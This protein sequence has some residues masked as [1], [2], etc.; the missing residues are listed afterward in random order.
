MSSLRRV[1][2]LISAAAA[3]AL[4]LGGCASSGTVASKSTGGVLGGPTGAPS[5]PGT[6]SSSP[7]APSSSDSSSPSTD[8]SSS[9]DSSDSGDSAMQQQLKQLAGVMTDPGCKEAVNALGDIIALQ[10]D[11]LKAAG[12]FPQAL[13]KIRQGAA[14]TK[15]PE[16]KT[17]I[18]KLADD[19]Q[20]IFTTAAKG[21]SP[22]MSGITAD[23]QAFGMACVG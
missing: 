11:P 17:S 6:S 8:D 5:A 23:S 4:L 7:D 14:T 22:D 1:P 19:L 3:A 18:N 9:S 10:N 2:V 12:A 15:K 13:A 20:N 16:A 21:G